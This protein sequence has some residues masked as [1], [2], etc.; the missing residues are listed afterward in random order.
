MTANAVLLQKKYTRV[1]ALFAAKCGISLDDA[2]EFFY[3][4][5]EYQL[6]RK[7]VADLHC[8]SDDYLAEDLK[9]EYLD[10]HMSNA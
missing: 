7:G 1:I 9:D 4:S 2:L 10:K 6:L 8:M 3:R 5:E